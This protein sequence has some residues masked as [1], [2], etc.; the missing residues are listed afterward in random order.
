M[1]TKI[2]INIQKNLKVICW[3]LAIVLFALGQQGYAQDNPEPEQETVEKLK[4]ILKIMSNKNDDNSRTI[5]GLFS[6]RDKETRKFLE[7]KGITLD[8]YVGVDSILKLGSFKTDED[9][10]AV[11]TINPDLQLPKDEEGYIHFIVEFVGNDLF[12]AADKEL[13][14]IDLQLE[15]SLEVLDSV[16]TVTVKAEKILSNDEKVPLNEEDIPIYVQRMFSQLKIGEISLEEGQ[17]RFEFPNNIP[18]DTLGMITLIAKYED[19]D[20]FANVSKNESIAWGIVTS[21][22]TIYH[23]RSLWTTVAPVWMIVTLSIMLLGVWGHYIFVI[24]EMIKL[25]KGKKEIAE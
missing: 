16:K 17:G 1:K 9:G 2:Y 5:V 13:D 12:M 20:D 18:G 23:P 14:L 8:F 3:V 22:H 24:F 21:H 10:K 6:Y 15:L 7:V 25:K 19:H 4:P 11:C